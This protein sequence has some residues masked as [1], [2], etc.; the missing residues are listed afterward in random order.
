MTQRAFKFRASLSGN[1]YVYTSVRAL[2][3]PNLSMIFFS[4]HSPVID[5]YTTDISFESN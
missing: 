3:A 5:Y 4:F 2:C 1:I